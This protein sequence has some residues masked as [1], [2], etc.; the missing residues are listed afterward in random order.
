MD[1][2]SS[3][4]IKFS[5]IFDQLKLSTRFTLNSV[6][7]LLQQHYKHVDLNK[8]DFTFVYWLFKN[9]AI[10][11]QELNV[12]KRMKSLLFFL[13]L[14]LAKECLERSD[15]RGR[16]YRGFQATTGAGLRFPMR[17]C[18]PWKPKSGM[19]HNFCRNPDNSPL[20]PWCWVAESER[21]PGLPPYVSVKFSIW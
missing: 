14:I 13:E 16:N 5:P 15:P 19:R 17:Q 20:G 11:K 10:Q 4:T 18:G 1:L 8:H 6:Q 2:L 7:Q 21:R 12:I 3:R 9:P